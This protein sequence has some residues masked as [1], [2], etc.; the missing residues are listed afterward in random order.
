[1][2]EHSRA[3]IEKITNWQEKQNQQKELLETYESGMNDMFLR[4]DAEYDLKQSQVI[5]AMEETLKAESARFACVEDL[6]DLSA[7][8]VRQKLFEQVSLV[9]LHLAITQLSN[10]L[11]IAYFFADFS[12]SFDRSSPFL[13][14]SHRKTFNARHSRY[15]SASATFG[16]AT[17]SARSN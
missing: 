7:L 5:K 16:T 1:M 10:A 12:D 2:D 4:Y 14:H 15:S 13:A 3:L 9:S 6:K 17:S 11:N 8:E